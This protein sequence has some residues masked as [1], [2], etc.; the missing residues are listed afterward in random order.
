[1]RN[2]GETTYKTDSKTRGRNRVY[3][4][5][6][7]KEMSPAYSSVYPRV[8]RNKLLLPR[9]L[10]LGLLKL[11]LPFFLLL[12]PPLCLLLSSPVLL[13]L[14]QPPNLLLKQPVFLFSSA[15]LGFPFRLTLSSEFLNR[16][17]CRLS[18][19]GMS[20]MKMM[21]QN[22]VLPSPLYVS[23]QC[24]DQSRLRELSRKRGI[25]SGFHQ[26]ALQSSPDRL[27]L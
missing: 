4:T 22:Q 27:R 12:S 24:T 3:E 9:I 6:K 26:V 2:G 20:M 21:K 25:L 17:L 18:R 13:L 1:M 11:S 23:D 10:L 16:E 19:H 14:S 5:V 15:I 8:N 7:R